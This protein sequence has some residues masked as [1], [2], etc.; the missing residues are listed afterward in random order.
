MARNSGQWFVKSASYGT[1]DLL[2]QDLAIAPGSGSSPIVVTVSNQTGSLTGVAT[3]NGNAASVWVYLIPTGPSATPVYTTRSG[4]D[5]SINLSYLPP[6]TYQAIAFESRHSANYRDPKAFAAYSTYLHSVSVNPGE[7][8]T[9]SV[10]A[11][12]TTEL[13][14]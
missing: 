12:P 11:I 1:A 6:G 5:G 13:V 14:P 3:L 2:Q 7:K 10:D 8:T 4:A 9:L